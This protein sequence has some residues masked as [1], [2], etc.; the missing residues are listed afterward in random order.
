MCCFQ[1]IYYQYTMPRWRLKFSVCIAIE[2]FY[3]MP[4]PLR[5]QRTTKEIRAESIEWLQGVWPKIIPVVMEMQ[6]FLC[7]F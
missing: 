7:Q 3:L 4:S 2:L 5:I 6:I 1:L